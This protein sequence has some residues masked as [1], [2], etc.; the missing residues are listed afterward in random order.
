[1]SND[2]DRWL[3]IDRRLYR[4][5]ELVLES[6]SPVTS[7]AFDHEGS[8]WVAAD[9][10]HRLKPALFRTYGPADGAVVNVYPIFEDSAKRI[11]LGSLSEGIARYEDGSTMALVSSRAVPALPWS[12]PGTP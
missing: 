12:C 1:M 6:R 11:W 8:L 10:L 2:G 7:I 5:E 4:N 3:G 9:G